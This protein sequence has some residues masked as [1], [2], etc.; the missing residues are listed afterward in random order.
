MAK[1]E[2]LEEAI[3]RYG[4]EKNKKIK[5]YGKELD[6]VSDP[7]NPDDETIVVEGKERGSANV[8]QVQ[9]PLSVVEMAK[10]GTRNKAK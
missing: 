4:N 7:I 3:R 1:P 2:I 6:L 5:L 9:V 8:K 10:R